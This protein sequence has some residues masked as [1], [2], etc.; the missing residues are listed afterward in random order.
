VANAFETNSA[1]A[2]ASA[3]VPHKYAK[4]RIYAHFGR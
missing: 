3:A 2:G 1:I 4:L